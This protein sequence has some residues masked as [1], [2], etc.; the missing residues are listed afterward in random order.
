MPFFFNKT[1][2][3]SKKDGDGTT[4]TLSSDQYQTKTKLIRHVQNIPADLEAPESAQE[5]TIKLI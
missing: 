5:T 4:D 1:P 3:S 2:L